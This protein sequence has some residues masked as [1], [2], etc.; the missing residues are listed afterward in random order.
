VPRR[1]LVQ[2]VGARSSSPGVARL[3]LWCSALCLAA[4][5]S[6]ERVVLSEFMAANGNG[7]TDKDGDTSDWI[8]LFNASQGPINLADWCLS[9]DPREPRRWC[10]PEISLP[11]RGFL[12]VFASG[13]RQLSTD[14]SE[15]H[16]SFKLK[17]S[18]DYL[19][20]TRPRGSVA[21]E[22]AYPDQKQDVA[23]GMSASGAL[24]FLARPTPRAPNA[25]L[26]S[27]R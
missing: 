11:A 19:G 8:E 18:A 22:V 1:A 6:S 23:Y 10:F 17:A 16:T 14:V 21:S 5:G 12:V 13:K 26:A 2:Q 15:L 3:A 7:L 4:C 25:E 20:L 27:K 24:G 9:D